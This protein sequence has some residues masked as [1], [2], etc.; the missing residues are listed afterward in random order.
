V[1]LKFSVGTVSKELT[2]SKCIIS[3][4]SQFTTQMVNWKSVKSK[5]MLQLCI[6]NASIINLKLE[7]RASTK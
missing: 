4:K 3:P 7:S 5:N 2:I 6:N 1:L